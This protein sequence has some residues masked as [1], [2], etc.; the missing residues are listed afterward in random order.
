MTAPPN[1]LKFNIYAALD[2]M[3]TEL[4]EVDHTCKTASGENLIGY[5]WSN[6]FTM[7]THLY[8]NLVCLAPHCRKDKPDHE[9]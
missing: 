4:E 2:K 1:H 8:G 3:P 7:V 5:S 6:S 9:A